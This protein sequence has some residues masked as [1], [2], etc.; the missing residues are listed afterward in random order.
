MPKSFLACF[1][2]AA[3]ATA[4]SP[5]HAEPETS[6]AQKKNDTS[7]KSPEPALTLS[8]KA[9]NKCE[10]ITIAADCSAQE[11][12]LSMQMPN[13]KGI[14]IA[15]YR[16]NTY[17]VEYGLPQ[18]L[19]LNA[20]LIQLNADI[21]GQAEF[22]MA[23]LKYERKLHESKRFAFGFSFE[24][25]LSATHAKL[26][27]DLGY[28]VNY[29]V[30]SKIP[31]PSSYKRE[32]HISKRKMTPLGR[33][34]LSLAMSEPVNSHLDFESEVYAEASPLEV[35]SGGRVG[36]VARSRELRIRQPNPG[37]FKGNTPTFISGHR[38]AA[39]VDARYTPFNAV[40][41]LVDKGSEKVSED[42]NRLSPWPRL[43]GVDL[44]PEALLELTGFKDPSGFSAV[45][46]I[47]AS[48]RIGALGYNVQAETPVLGGRPSSFSAS[49]SFTFK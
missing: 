42:L 23:M 1:A 11:T 22:E 33:A 44:S 26:D 17:K 28:N 40:S 35:F 41:Y 20:P 27:A 32:T 4:A 43:L 34:D 47:S 29:P 8:F 5:A 48:G 14:L 45:T 21:E 6:P 19:Q 46:Y 15:S 10:V 12:S 7:P 25:G 31:L 49:L 18:I 39:G 36:I 16:R 37:G 30:P 13:D 24:F 3:T 38:I 2:L 9:G